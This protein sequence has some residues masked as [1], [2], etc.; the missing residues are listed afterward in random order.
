MD[1]VG[2]TRNNQT[3]VYNFDD[4]NAAMWF[5]LVQAKKLGVQFPRDID[6]YAYTDTDIAEVMDEINEQKASLG[7]DIIWT[8]EN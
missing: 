4:G 7:F 5:V 1:S 2:I 3:K 6:D 8:D